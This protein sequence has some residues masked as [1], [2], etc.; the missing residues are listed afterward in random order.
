[1]HER[2][3]IIEIQPIGKYLRIRALDPVTLTEITTLAPQSISHSEA[4]HLASAKLQFVL[5][6]KNNE[7]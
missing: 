6:R 3:F 4:M 2:N 1:M 7:L 5:Q